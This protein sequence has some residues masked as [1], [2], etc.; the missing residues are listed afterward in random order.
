MQL[1]QDC[2]ACQRNELVKILDLGTTPLANSL[3]AKE[4][5]DTPE[6][7]APLAVLLCQSCA[8]LQLSCTILPEKLFRNYPYFS[9]FS[10]T[11]LKHSEDL[12]SRL[13]LQ[14]QLNTNSFVVEIASN[15]GYLL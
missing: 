14:R 3:L 7:V 6:F 15:D 4:Q 10:D 1:I 2:R 8:L 13:I 12:C 5:L 11:M 9:S